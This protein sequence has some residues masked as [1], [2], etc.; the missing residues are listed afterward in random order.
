M[1]LMT[2]NVKFTIVQSNTLLKWQYILWY[3]DSSAGKLLGCKL[4]L[5]FHINYFSTVLSAFLVKLISCAVSL[6]VV[7]YAQ[8]AIVQCNQPT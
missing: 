5:V 2:E 8:F 4:F 1:E 6:H 3:F 7:L